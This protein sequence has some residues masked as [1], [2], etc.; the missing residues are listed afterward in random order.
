MARRRHLD[1]GEVVI[2]SAVSL[3]SSGDGGYVL[4]VELNV[5]ALAGVD[6]A[7]ASELIREAHRVCP[8]SNATRGNIEVSL[9]LEGEELVGGS[10]TSTSD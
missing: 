4:A 1:V 10:V 2:D 7:T 8:Y 3:R 9:L 5:G 6:R